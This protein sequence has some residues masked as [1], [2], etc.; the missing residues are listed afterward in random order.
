MR[1]FISRKNLSLKLQNHNKDNKICH[2]KG[3]SLRM[4]VRGWVELDSPD[5]LKPLLTGRECIAS[6]YRYSQVLMVPF[7]LPGLP[8]RFDQAAA[9]CPQDDSSGLECN[10]LKLLCL[11]MQ[12]Q[13]IYSICAILG[14]VFSCTSFHCGPIQVCPSKS[15][16][17]RAIPN[18]TKGHATLGVF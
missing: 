18:N 13:L 4:K 9:Y 10:W 15:I 1:D 5:P 7:S 17:T 12:E 11:N 2:G 16:N 8:C 3:N 6:L 14:A